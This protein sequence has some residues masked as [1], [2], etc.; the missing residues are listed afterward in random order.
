MVNVMTFSQ[1]SSPN[2]VVAAQIHVLAFPLQY[3]IISAGSGS[4]L[5]YFLLARPGVLKLGVR[6][7]AMKD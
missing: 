2:P 1:R 5:D 4:R 3:H 7:E 6:A